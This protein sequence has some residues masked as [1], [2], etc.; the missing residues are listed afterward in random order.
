MSAIPANILA[1]NALAFP[2]SALVK[3]LSVRE[4]VQYALPN[5]YWCQFLEQFEVN[6]DIA[7]RFWVP[8][9]F[10]SDGASIP[11][12]MWNVLD[13][14]DP[15]ILFPSYAHDYLYAMCGQLAGTQLTKDQCD[16]VIR[17]LMLKCGAP[18]WKANGVYAGLNVGGGKAWRQAEAELR[19]PN[20]QKL[21]YVG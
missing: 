4:I 5:K 11:K 16:R 1:L 6:S 10:L 7:G 13:P 12:W 9:G 21:A 20:P 2:Q 15:E 18:R 14:C 17:E 3:D 8:K 19:K